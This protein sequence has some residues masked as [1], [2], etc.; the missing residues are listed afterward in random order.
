MPGSDCGLLTCLLDR[1][2]ALVDQPIDKGTYGARQ[3]L[4]D[5][6]IGDFPE[7]AV[8]SGSRQCDDSR[9]TAH[10]GPGAFERNVALRLLI[11][12]YR[13][14]ECR[15]DECLNRRRRTKTGGQMKQFGACTE[16]EFFDFRV[17]R[18]VRAAKAVDGLLRIADE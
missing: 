10:L 16:E 6:P 14:R 7:I 12:G 17:K 8:G 18:D 11:R 15:I 1:P 4:I 3:G 13:G 2:S 5:A 9:A